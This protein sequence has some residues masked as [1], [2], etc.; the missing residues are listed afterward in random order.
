MIIQFQRFLLQ[1]LSLKLFCKWF[2]SVYKQFMEKLKMLD[3]WVSSSIFLGKLQANSTPASLPPVTPTPFLQLPAAQ[4]LTQQSSYWQSEMRLRLNALCIYAVLKNKAAQPPNE[5]VTSE[6]TREWYS[7]WFHPQHSSQR[8][9][10][11]GNTSI[12]L[13]TY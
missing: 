12:M 3:Y 10:K 5:T 2:Y 6:W 4:I 9:V 1:L 11:E 8:H 13:S 7:V